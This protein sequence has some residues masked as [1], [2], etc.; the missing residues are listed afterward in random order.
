MTDDTGWIMNCDRSRRGFYVLLVLAVIAVSI[1]IPRL[2]DNNFWSDECFSI[3]LLKNDFQDIWWAAAGDTHPPLF[4]YIGFFVT[5]IFGFN[6]VSFHLISLLALVVILVIAL[7]WVRIRF[8]NAAAAVLM[9][10][11]ALLSTSLMYSVEVRMYEWCAVFVLLTFMML[12]EALDKPILSNLALVVAFGLAAAYTHIYGLI[13]VASMYLC[14]LVGSFFKRGIGTKNVLLMIVSSLVLYA[15]WIGA[16]LS[17]M[18]RTS[19]FWITGNP[20]APEILEYLFQT[21][22]AIVSVLLSVLAIVLTVLYLIRGT[23]VLS[24]LTEALMS[25]EDDG[26]TLWVAICVSSIVLTMVIAAALSDI[27]RPYFVLRYIYPICVL[28]WLL[29][30]IGAG[31]VKHGIVV[32]AAIIAVMLAV[33]VPYYVDLRGDE[34]DTDAAIADTLDMTSE[35]GDD[36]T[37]Y[38]PMVWVMD[39][40]YPD[41]SNLELN[42]GALDGMDHSSGQQYWLFLMEPISDELTN[43]VGSRGFSP[44]FYYHGNL[45][46]HDTWIYRIV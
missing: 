46:S 33:C 9:V 23:G 28:A 14:V 36:D 16:I 6:N 7:T 17:A 44:E 31:A 21:D 37:T 2:F 11:S 15:P 10:S 5:R 45:G 12:Y 3:N 13:A 38:S 19:D 20:T 24:K 32:A 4:Y 40:Y 34:R 26:K 43:K 42:D 30:G 1:N 18:N 27:I 25:E 41:A 35:I 22:V 39:Y 29:L 8:G